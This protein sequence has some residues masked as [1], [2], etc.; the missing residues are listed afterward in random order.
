M[1]HPHDR[2]CLCAGG[3]VSLT[4]RVPSCTSTGSFSA[5]QT[6]ASATAPSSMPAST[7]PPASTCTTRWTSPWT[8]PKSRWGV[9][10]VRGWSRLGVEL[11]GGGAGRGW[12]RLGVEQ[13]GGGAGRGWSRLGVEQVGGGAGGG[14]SMQVGGGA[15]R[16]SEVELILFLFSACLVSPRCSITYVSVAVRVGAKVQFPVPVQ[17]V[18]PSVGQLRPALPGHDSAGQVCRGDGRPAL[19]HPH[20][21]ALWDNVRR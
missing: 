15:G 21:A 17:V 5:T 16:G 8:N 10:L 9:K 14:W 13:V 3:H 11:V 12:S 20:G 1:G 4:R 7:A 2:L 18:P 6:R 19:G